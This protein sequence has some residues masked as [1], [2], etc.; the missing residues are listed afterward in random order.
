MCSPSINS[1]LL[2]GLPQTQLLSSCSPAVLPLASFCLFGNCGVI[3]IGFISTEEQQQ[4]CAVCVSDVVVCFS[5]SVFTCDS[6]PNTE[7]SAIAS[8]YL[9]LTRLSPVSHLS[10]RAAVWPVT[11]VFRQAMPSSFALSAPKIRC[12]S[13]RSRRR[14]SSGDTGENE[15]NGVNTLQ[16]Y[17]WRHVL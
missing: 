8:D 10:L 12:T 7:D 1:A 17:F 5:L 2:Q 9:S 6:D 3:F 16:V 11:A 14:T 15:C 4:S 13:S